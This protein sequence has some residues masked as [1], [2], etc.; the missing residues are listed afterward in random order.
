MQSLLKT[1]SF[2]TKALSNSSRR[3]ISVGD[4]IPTCNLKIVEFKNDDYHT[5]V[6]DARAAFQ[7]QKV[8]LIGY[9]GFF[10]NIT[11]I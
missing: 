1:R 3:Y 5:S 10:H 8:I 2:L 4:E 11:I 9:P 6:L 7:D